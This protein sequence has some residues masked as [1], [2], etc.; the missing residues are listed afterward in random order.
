MREEANHKV[1]INTNE[2]GDL[3]PEVPPRR[4]YVPI[5]EATKAGS[6][7]TLPSLKRSRRPV[8]F[9]PL[10]T[11]TLSPARSSTRSIRSLLPR[12]TTM[13]IG[14]ESESENPNQE[15]KRMQHS[16]AQ[17]LKPLITQINRIG[18]CVALESW[19]LLHLKYIAWW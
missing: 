2:R 11:R 9:A 5:E 18:A 15:H 17:A 12:F 6:L 3:F 1:L 8:E 14:G 7:S 19:E 10:I 4:I 16:R 13:R